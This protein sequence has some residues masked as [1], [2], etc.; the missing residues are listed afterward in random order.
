[1]LVD[2]NPHL[3][4]QKQELEQIG[5]TSDSHGQK[6]HEIGLEFDTT[7][8]C[9]C[10]ASKDL[11]ESVEA[12]QNW[13]GS[14][15]VKIGERWEV[16]VSISENGSRCDRMRVMDSRSLWQGFENLDWEFGNFGGFQ[17]LYKGYVGVIWG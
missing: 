7:L 17:G 13:L 3:V 8:T 10:E 12:V 11:N 16:C 4:A 2:F 5:C 1:M 6:F 15:F 9:S 14:C